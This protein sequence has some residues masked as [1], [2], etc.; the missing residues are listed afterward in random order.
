MAVIDFDEESFEEAVTRLGA[1][2]I[3]GRS[4]TTFHFS[5]VEDWPK[6][7]DWF[8][9]LEQF[10]DRAREELYQATGITDGLSLIR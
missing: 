4:M 1:I 7:E 8:I 5:P 6:P 10:R 3:D 9:Q 2:G